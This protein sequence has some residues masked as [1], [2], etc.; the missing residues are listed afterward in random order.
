MAADS[1]GPPDPGSTLVQNPRFASSGPGWL[2]CVGAGSEGDE[3]PDVGE[4]AAVAVA[5]DVA[6][7][8]G[9]SVVGGTGGTGAGATGGWTGGGCGAGIG[10]GARVGAGVGAALGALMTTAAGLTAV[11]PAVFS[12]PPLPLVAE[13]R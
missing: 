5:L 12:P 6:D 9:D 7:A 10:T 4:G 11:K 3:P 13:N 1:T 8:I 2:D